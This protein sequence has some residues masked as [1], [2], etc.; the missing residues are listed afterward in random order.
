LERIL[1]QTVD[2]EL[3]GP[4]CNPQGLEITR[5]KGLSRSRGVS[6]FRILMLDMRQM[7][8]KNA[9]TLVWWAFITG[10][11]LIAVVST[12]GRSYHQLSIGILLTSLT[13]FILLSLL[14]FVWRAVEML[15]TR[16]HE[17]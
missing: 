17:Q 16:R 12:R 9:R 13:L 15:V 8:A 11:A 4:R 1:A 10:L 7:I 6:F 3:G 2:L 14:E 5:S